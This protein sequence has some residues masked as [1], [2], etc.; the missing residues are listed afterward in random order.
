MKTALSY[1]GGF[2]AWLSLELANISNN[3]AS[4]DLFWVTLIITDYFAS[5]AWT[6]KV[7]CNNTSVFVHPY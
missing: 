3:Q 4:Y 5:E 2:G 1:A 6:E 7:W